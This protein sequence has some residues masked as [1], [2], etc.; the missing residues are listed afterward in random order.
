MKINKKELKDVLIH[1]R[2]LLQMFTLL[3][4][5][6]GIAIIVPRPSLGL[7]SGAISWLLLCIGITLFNSYYDKDKK[8]VA[9]LRVPP[10]VNKLMLCTAIGLK[11]IATLTGLFL[12]TELFIAVLIASLLSVAYSH[13]SIRLK[14]NPFG[15]V[16]FNFIAGS[17]TFYAVTSFSQEPNRTDVLLGQFCSGCF[18][19]GVY[20]MMQIHQIEEDLERGYVSIALKIGAERT[21]ALSILIIVLAGIIAMYL[22]EKQVG[23]T[24]LFFC[25]VF[26]FLGIFISVNWLKNAEKDSFDKMSFLTNY[27]S[28]G[29]FLICLSAY[30]IQIAGA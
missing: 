28:I 15:S 7:F 25:I 9:G 10:P 17:L 8:P 6:F 22:L 13:P 20:M 11:I 30:I 5:V 23:M 21:I 3:G 26:L 4:F 1:T 19:A 29:G 16:G 24:Y 12:N 14:S 2:H 27:L 18:L